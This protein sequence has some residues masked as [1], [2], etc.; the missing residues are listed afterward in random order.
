MRGS[1]PIVK[2]SSARP[3][4]EGV[5]APSDAAPLLPRLL[6][7]FLPRLAIPFSQYM[8]ETLVLIDKV[9]LTGIAQQ[10]SLLWA[11]P[12]ARGHTRLR[13]GGTVQ[14][15]TDSVYHHLR[16]IPLDEMPAALYN[17]VDTIG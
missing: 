6:L 16:L 13:L 8:R 10:A 15:P 14:D 3:T 1:E 9:N 4:A 5:A 7:F 12:Y 17:H 11:V 2:C